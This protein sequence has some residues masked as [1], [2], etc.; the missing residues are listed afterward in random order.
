VILVRDSGEEMS[1][2][3]TG[4]A[5]QRIKIG[6]DHSS[7]HLNP[8][9][10]SLI[11]SPDRAADQDRHGSL[12]GKEQRLFF[13]AWGQ[14][15]CDVERRRAQELQLFTDEHAPNKLRVNGPLMNFDAFAQVG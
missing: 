7:L 4:C 11:S 10:I 1:D 14:N 2:I 5:G 3:G 6:T 12:S 9:L 8:V 15:W 13:L